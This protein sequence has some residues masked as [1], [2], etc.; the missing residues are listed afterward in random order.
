MFCPFSLHNK[1]VCQSD[2]ALNDNENIHLNY[3]H[4]LT[5][6]PKMMTF[7]APEK[8]LLENTVEKVTSTFSFCHDF[9]L[10][11]DKQI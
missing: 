4:K 2:Q 1:S 3:Q 9:F 5:L 8:K 7:D 11:H 6:Y 10:P